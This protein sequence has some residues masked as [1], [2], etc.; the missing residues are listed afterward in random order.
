[1]FSRRRS[2]TA[3][4]LDLGSSYCEFDSRRR[5][6]SFICRGDEIGSRAA[7]R[8]LREF[9]S[10]RVRLPPST[11]VFSWDGDV[12]DSIKVL[13]TFCQGLNPCRSTNFCSRSQTAKATVSK[14]VLCG[15]DSRRE[16]QCLF[17]ARSPIRQRRLI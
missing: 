13:Q 2:Q 8:A 17:C 10:M 7:L 16:Y 11:L 6:F 4:A 14:I 1:M 5:Y 3:K 15:F 12:I 9:F